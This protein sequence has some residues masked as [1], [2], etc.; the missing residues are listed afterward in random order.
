MSKPKEH[1]VRRHGHRLY[2]VRG[3]A[4]PGYTDSHTTVVH[5]G[6]GTPTVFALRTANVAKWPVVSAPVERD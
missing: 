5:V 3:D 4:G 2:Y 6:A 1:E